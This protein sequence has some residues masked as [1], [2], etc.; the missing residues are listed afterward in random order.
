VRAG[1][2]SH[3]RAAE[4]ELLVPRTE[5]MSVAITAATVV[6]EIAGLIAINAARWRFRQIPLTSTWVRAT[7]ATLGGYLACTGRRGRGR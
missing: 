4:L 5:A 2:E 1:P 3:L 6:R 7:T